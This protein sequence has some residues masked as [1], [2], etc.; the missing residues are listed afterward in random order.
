METAT[1]RFQ[2]SCYLSKIQITVTVDTPEGGGGGGHLIC[3]YG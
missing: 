1:V 2:E 3:K